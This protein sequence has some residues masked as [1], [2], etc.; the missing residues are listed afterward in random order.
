[1]TALYRQRQ[2]IG[3][4]RGLA[5][6]TGARRRRAHRQPTSARP[7]CSQSLR[8]SPV[9]ASMSR[10]QFGMVRRPPGR[11]RPGIASRCAGAAA[12]QRRP[13][14]PAET[15]RCATS[16]SSRW[17]SRTTLRRIRERP[18]TEG[19]TTGARSS[20]ATSRQAQCPT[21][22]ASTHSMPTA[23]CSTTA[24]AT[25]SRSTSPTQASRSPT[26]STTAPTS[27]ASTS[28]AVLRST[29]KAGCPQAP[30]TDSCGDVGRSPRSM[31]PVRR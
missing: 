1:M 19:S 31:S 29:P 24:A 27:S 30:S 22:R 4:W 14:T 17:E 13:A 3:C 7:N 12:N 16:S 20:A 8:G 23:P 11:M 18:R 15:C 26:P 28:M 10:N 5:A 21:P 9:N 6:P 25:S 2:P